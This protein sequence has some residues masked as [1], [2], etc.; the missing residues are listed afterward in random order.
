MRID[1]LDKLSRKGNIFTFDDAYRVSNINRS[2]LKVLLNRL[3]KQ[4]WIERIE[5]GKYIII[6]LGAKKAAYTLNEF[7]IAFILV[8][9]SA[10]SYWSAL[11]YHGFTEQI[12]N[13]VFIQTIARK[14]YQE[15][16][17]FGIKY[18]IVRI[19]EKKF[20]GLQ[21]EIIED[22]KINL[23][24]RE[25]TIADCLDKPQY[26]GG[27]IEVA[28]AIK[29]K[30]YDLDRLLEYAKKIGNTGVIRRLGYLLG[31]YK[32]PSNITPVATRNYLYLNPGFVKN[33]KKESK[34]KLVINLDERELI[35]L[36]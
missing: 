22:S 11:N 21:Q 1:I 24:D 8:Q 27:I 16:K 31:L 30:N 29:S 20:F 5:K 7:I 9:P 28:K 2:I 35:N 15:K 17:I 6:P 32:I 3:E 12:P 10:I 34:W 14:K 18:K 26:C 4:G 25:K 36:E 19:I 23:T 13:T 33:G